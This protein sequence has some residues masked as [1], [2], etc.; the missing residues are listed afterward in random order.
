[1][2]RKTAFSLALILAVLTAFAAAQPRPNLALSRVIYFTLKSQVKLQGDLRDKIAAL[3]KDMAEAARAGRTGEVPPPAGQRVVLLSGRE[4]TDELEF[5]ASLVLRAEETYADSGR[6]YTVRV[7]QICA[8]KIALSDPLAVRLSLH[9]PGRPG[10]GLGLQTGEKV[11]DLAAVDGVS[12]DLQD[13]P[14]RIEF[15]PTGV[16][17]GS[18]D[19]VAELYENAHPLGKALLRVDFR[20]GLSS[21]LAALSSGVA[22]VQ[23]FDDLRADVLYPAD[24]IQAVNGGR[25]GRGTFDLEAEL[26]R[27][28]SVLTSIRAGRDPFAG[29]TGDME[30]HY[31][32]DGAN[33]IMPYRVYVPSKYDGRTAYP[34]IIALHGLGATQDSFF[35]SYGREFPKLA[36]KHG[37]IVAAPLGYRDDGGYGRSLFGPSD[38]PCAQPENRIQREGRP[39]RPGPD[40]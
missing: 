28:E 38:R 3:D 14:C 7:E 40:A 26:K 33:E 39:G 2:R 16:E 9:K 19:L 13:E 11:R 32:L 15:D 36:E 17:D 34:L 31:L 37:Y 29:R 4:W 10:Y 6:P 23:G 5:S 25:T 1:M 27:A 35:D 18:Y 22:G 20:R 30:R 21:R 8:P 24:F 12:R